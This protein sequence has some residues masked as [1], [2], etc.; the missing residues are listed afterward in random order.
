MINY[1]KHIGSYTLQQ[2]KRYYF[3][4]LKELFGTTIK[5]VNTFVPMETED[6]R[7]TPELAAGSSQAKITDFVKVRSSKRV[8][9]AELDHEGF[10]RQK[11]NEAVNISR[12]P[13]E[14]EKEL[15]QEDL[16]QMMMVVP[17][18]EVYVEAL[19]DI[20]KI[21]DRDDLVMLWNLVKERFSSTEPTDDKE[22]ALWV[23]LKR[24]IVERHT[25]MANELQRKIF[26]QANRSINNVFGS[27][28]SGTEFQFRETVVAGN[29]SNGNASTKAYD[30]AGKA[31]MEKIPGKDYI[32]L[33]LSIQNPSFSSSSKDSPDA[34]FKPS[35]VDKR[36]MLKIRAES[37][38]QLKER[39]TN[40]V[41]AVSS[42]VNAVG[43]EVNVVN[44]KTSIELLNDLNMLELKD[45]V[46]LYDDEDVDAEAT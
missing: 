28:H 13:D 21:F 30:N 4:D 25:E 7:R 20:L 44:P 22:R 3:D 23:K 34:G 6:R 29:Q 32:L 14:E 15:S 12:Q 18:E 27:I 36:R 42:T 17:V 31:R 38:N 10:K 5:N 46:Y 45:I 19:Q 43:L 35:W 40:N 39:Y 37:G 1:I 8:V 41:N 33:P 11:T 2:L 9:E 26:E 16:Q 24:P